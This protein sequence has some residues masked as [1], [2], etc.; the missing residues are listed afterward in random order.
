[1][2]AGA[3]A[4]V[5]SLLKNVR[6]ILTLLAPCFKLEP[7]RK[8]PSMKSIPRT[9]LLLL[10]CVAT[11]A[12]LVPG[13]AKGARPHP[14]DS[15]IVESKTV[16][17]VAGPCGSA[18]LKVR[19][20]MTN[21]DSL[22]NVTVPLEQKSLS[23]GAYAALSRKADCKTRATGACFSYLGPEGSLA[24]RLSNFKMYN[25]VSP[26]T[27]LF[28]ATLGDP[29]SDEQKFPPSAKRRPLLDI[30]FDSVYGSG[31][32]VLDSG[33]VLANTIQF[34]S[35]NGRMIPVNFTKGIITVNPK[36]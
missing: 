16:A 9:P 18:G 1:L 5:H 34:V 32:F 4:P 28:T 10:L 8:K 3:S 6:K 11:A 36:K 33:R 15:I 25:G 30:Q 26:D 27:V 23:G 22:A 31:Q 7:E 19:V 20:W 21:K 29:T 13:T 35:L 24:S 2:L 17:P 14:S 12:L